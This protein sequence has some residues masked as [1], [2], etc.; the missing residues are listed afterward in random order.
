MQ[1]FSERKFTEAIETLK[2][3][4]VIDPIKIDDLIYTV[5]RQMG[6]LGDTFGKN[7]SYEFI[8]EKNVKGVLL[9]RVYLLKFEKMCLKFDFRFYNNGHGWTITNFNYSEDIDDLLN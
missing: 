4:S 8:A 9:K 3:Y 1:T 5:E 2:I 6:I 7:L